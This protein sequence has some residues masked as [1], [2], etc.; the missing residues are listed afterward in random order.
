[1]RVAVTGA[2]G[3]IGRSLVKSLLERGD[4]VIAFSRRPEPVAA[5]PVSLTP[6]AWPPTGVFPTVDAVIHLAG[7][8]VDGRWTEEKKAAIRASRSEGTRALV[9]A[10]GAA[11]VRPAALISASAIGYY[12]DRGEEVIT[13]SAEAGDG[14]LADACVQWEQAAYEAVSLGLRVATVRTGVVLDRDGGAIRKM[15]P[16][17]RMGL[18][19]PMGSG[20][21]W[22]AWIHRDDIVG[23][24][25]H[26]LDTGLDG[27]VNGASPN[28]VRQRDFAT[29]LGSVLCRPAILP[30]PSFALRLAFGEFAGTFFHSQRVLP[31]KAERNGFTFRYPA[32][33]EA[34]TAALA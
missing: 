31:E 15:L 17:Y 5:D 2:A 7:E 22:F 4:S 32:L 21:Q 19:G 18:G 24:Y 10:I 9:E 28:P 30:T 27:P 6:A 1:M 26:L 8:P 12:G 13:E 34:L 16:A 25:L 11:P 3:F 33:R 23:L 29:T 20:S 14:F